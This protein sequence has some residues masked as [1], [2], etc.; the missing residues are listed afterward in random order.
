[1]SCM[2]SM[3]SSQWVNLAAGPYREDS[4]NGQG[5]LAGLQARLGKS[6]DGWQGSSR[7]SGSTVNENTFS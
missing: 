4:V 7:S 3:G 1:M 2:R 5:L 6:A